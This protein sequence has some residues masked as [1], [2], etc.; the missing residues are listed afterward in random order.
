[1]HAC[2]SCH[3][4]GAHHPLALRWHALGRLST[5]QPW[6]HA[7][8][9]VPNMPNEGQTRGVTNIFRLHGLVRRNLT[10]SCSIGMEAMSRRD[11]DSQGRPKFRPHRIRG[12]QCANISNSSDVYVICDMLAGGQVQLG[13]ASH[14]VPSNGHYCRL[15]HKE[16]ICT[17]YAYKE[18]S[19]SSNAGYAEL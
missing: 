11:A 8:L 19:I 4:T 12:L 15:V 3:A 5:W 1:M 9:S 17:L 2:A 6:L 7:H 18:A 10:V 16:K 14:G 13:A